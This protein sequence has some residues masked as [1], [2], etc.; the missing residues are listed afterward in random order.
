M[1]SSAEPT[2]ARAVD[3]AW[4]R[5]ACAR[6]SCCWA[7][8]VAA[9]IG[10]ERHVGLL[11]LVQGGQRV[12]RPLRRTGH[13]SIAW[14]WSNCARKLPSVRTRLRPERAAGANS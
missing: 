8:A 1:K 9:R 10:V 4:A 2:S 7:S 3:S 13:P 12:G 11:H 14:I 5:P 6:C